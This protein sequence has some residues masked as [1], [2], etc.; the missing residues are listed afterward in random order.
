M[1]MHHLLPTACCRG[2]GPLSLAELGTHLP[3][4]GGAAGLWPD[5]AFPRYPLGSEQLPRTA[6]MPGRLSVGSPCSKALWTQ[7]WN[8]HNPL[9]KEDTW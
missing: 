7:P 6:P 5:Q 2:P 1:W 9:C 3:C 8:L 4:P